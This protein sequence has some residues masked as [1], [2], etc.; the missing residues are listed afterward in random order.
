MSVQWRAK[1]LEFAAVTFNHRKE[2]LQMI[3][4]DC[5][6]FCGVCSPS[7]E[8]LFLIDSGRT[9]M[10]DG[11]PPRVNVQQRLTTSGAARSATVA[12]QPG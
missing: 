4:G 9:G 2:L 12:A 5:E 6:G 11:V 7:V 10:Q 1:L 8:S 3:H